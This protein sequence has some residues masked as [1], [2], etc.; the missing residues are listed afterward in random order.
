MRVWSV[1]LPPY[2]GLKEGHGCYANAICTEPGLRGHVVLLCF[3]DRAVTNKCRLH[4]LRHRALSDSVRHILPSIVGGT[5]GTR[6]IGELRQS[7]ATETRVSA[8]SALILDRR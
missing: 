2:G 3:V 6:L 7:L 1:T 4:I 8:R 5:S